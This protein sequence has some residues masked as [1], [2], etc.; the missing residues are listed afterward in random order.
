VYLVV[1]LI[2]RLA[3]TTLR[4]LSQHRT[5]PLRILDITPSESW[6]ITLLL[7]GLFLTLD[8]A[9]AGGLRVPTVRGPG[10]PGNDTFNV[11]D[12]PPGPSTVSSSAGDVELAT[13]RAAHEKGSG[14]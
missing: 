10:R 4:V 1:A 2:E 12:G 3:Q 9:G 6:T 5:R 8:V 13:R 14:G 11:A 7:A